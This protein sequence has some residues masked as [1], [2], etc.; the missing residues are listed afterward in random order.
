M[1]TVYIAYGQIDYEGSDTIGVFATQGE[2]FARC[3]AIERRREADDDFDCYY[4]RYCVKKWTVG[5]TAPDESLF[6]TRETAAK[7]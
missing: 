4:S 6:L 1:D 7:A 2:A 5:K 3:G